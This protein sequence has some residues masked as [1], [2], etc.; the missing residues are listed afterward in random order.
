M[1]GEDQTVQVAFSDEGEFLCSTR[2]V[3]G[4]AFHDPLAMPLDGIICIGLAERGGGVLGADVDSL[5]VADDAQVAECWVGE[6]FQIGG[7]G[8]LPS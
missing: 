8:G 4:V 7:H 3:K 6:Q 5:S 2:G 1:R